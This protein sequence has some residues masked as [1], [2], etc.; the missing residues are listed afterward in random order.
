MK[1]AREMKPCWRENG[2]STVP[3]LSPRQTGS[4]F[5]NGGL[6]LGLLLR[7]FAFAV[8]I[9]CFQVTFLGGMV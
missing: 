6:F 9:L 4:R 3:L 8:R 2:V 5:Q 1:L 7:Y